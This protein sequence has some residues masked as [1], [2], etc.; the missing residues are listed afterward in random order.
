MKFVGFP[1]GL[2]ITKEEIKNII[3]NQDVSEFDQALIVKSKIGDKLGECKLGK[4][5][6]NAISVTDIKLFPQYRNKGY[7]KEIKTALVEYLFNNTECIGVKA[8]PNKNNIASQKLQESIGAKRI[9]EGKF[10]FPQNMKSYTIDVE[11]YE[12]IVF[13]DDWLKNKSN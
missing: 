12:Y 4:P 13:K 11:Y 6:K 9:S 10:V 8:T 3:L 5:D 7:G 2:N 1:N